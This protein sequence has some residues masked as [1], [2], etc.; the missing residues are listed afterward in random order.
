[1]RLTNDDRTPPRRSHAGAA[2]FTMVELLVTMLLL[3]IVLVGLAALQVHAIRNVTSSRRTN[4]AI[5]LG[6]SVIERYRQMTTPP[7]ASGTGDWEPERGRDGATMVNVGADG[8]SNG[9]YTVDTFIE[10]SGGSRLITVR[11]KFMELTPT[12]A[13]TTY[14]EQQIYISTFKAP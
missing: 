9:P 8:E 1:M 5:R 14:K 13:A 11:V 4:E 10:D 7:A 6:Q 3:C 12:G 2:G